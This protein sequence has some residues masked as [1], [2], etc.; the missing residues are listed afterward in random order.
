MRL[1]L[2]VPHARRRVEIR[3]LCQHMRRADADN[4]AAVGDFNIHS[5][6]APAWRIGEPMCAGG[7]PLEALFHSLA[8]GLT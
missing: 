7:G 3:T 1:G 5:A 2:V 4:V 8:L 6:T